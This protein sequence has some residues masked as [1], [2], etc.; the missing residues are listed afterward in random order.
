MTQQELELP[1]GWTKSEL[2]DSSI[3]EIIMGQSPP[4]STYNKGKNGLPFFQ[5]KKDFG[6]KF[7]TPTVW[8]SIPKRLAEKGD[9]LLSVRAPVGKINWAN[10]KCCIGR[11]LS[12]IRPNIESGFVYY[13]LKS[14]E[15]NLSGSGAGSTFN[16]INKNELYKISISVPPLN[17]QKRIVS[18]IE[19][20]FSKIDSTKQSLEHGKLQLEQY[21]NPFLKSVF[22]HKST[23]KWTK[24]NLLDV[25]KKISSGSTPNRNNPEYFSGK[26]P[27]LKSGELN[28]GMIFDSEEKI[29]TAGF[30]NSS[31]T[32]FPKDTILIA[33]YGATI[34]KTGLLMIESTTN[35]AICGLECN[36]DMN[37]K[38][39]LYFL[40]SQYYNFLQK[41]SGGAQPN[42]NQD[43]IKKTEISYPALD[44]QSKIISQIED[45]LSK[46]NNTLNTVN[47]TLKQ[48]ETMRMSILK[49]AF[50][51][52]LVPQ[53]PNDEPASV[54]LE[55]IQ[56]E[57][58]KP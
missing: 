31:T 18:K 56:K 32:L 44:I 16:A 22:N 55:R 4:G 20:L 13:F 10:E 52:K 35:Q 48:L 27:W 58:I 5:G 47:S 50:E 37:S 19:E 40:Q 9:I 41:G 23:E 3:S 17:E 28:G 34:G 54:L 46:I 15:I 12:A 26:I 30:E 57:K 42:I 53:D 1:K 25:C 11:G 7:P 45:T 39:I 21:N 36:D 14:I 33:M 38:F 29:T 43:K 24:K 49:Q 6:E 2:G 51:G 8:C